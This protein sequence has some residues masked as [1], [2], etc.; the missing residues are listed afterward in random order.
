MKRVPWVL[1]HSPLTLTFGDGFK[2]AGALA[3]WIARTSQ[4]LGPGTR[5]LA[6][7]SQRHGLAADRAVWERDI[8][9][10]GPIGR[11]RL[12]GLTLL[13]AFR[14]SSSGEALTVAALLNKVAL[15]TR[16]LPVEQVV[17]LVDQADYGVGYDARVGVGQPGPIGPEAVP[18]LKLGWLLAPH[19]PN[20]LGYGVFF[21]PQAVPS[22]A[23]EIFVV[24]QEFIEAGTGDVHQSQLSL[25]RGG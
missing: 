2:R 13:S 12:I 10:I 17:G 1:R 6:S 8:G 7:R 15:K 18:G 20:S 11:I 4:K 25:G 24:E 21:A 23:D 19:C 14:D 5:P 16:D 22:L 3:V 9:R